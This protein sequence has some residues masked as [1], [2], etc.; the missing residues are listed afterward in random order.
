MLSHGR[1]RLPR[2]P[3]RQTGLSIVELLV[4]STIG[5]FLVG[6]AAKLFID[7]I[8]D[9]R[10]MIIETRVNQ[11]L[12]AAADLMARD[13]RR[14]GY[15]QAALAGAVYPAMLNPYRGTTPTSTATNSTTYAFSRDAT[16][17]NTLDGNES[18]GFRLQNNAIE[19]RVGS[20]TWQQVTDPG[21]VTVTQFTVTP[22]QRVV[23]V[24][25]YCTP[26]C[27]AGSAGCPSLVVRRFDIV[28]QGQAPS[29]ANVRREIRESVRLRNDEL[30]LASCP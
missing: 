2:H 7:S 25:Q 17:N 29:D 24:G 18:F 11:D 21:A 23:P 8:G 27:A 22:V 20:G 3:Q 16:E 12:R 5:L 10:R 14:A 15:W 4:G 30:P 28:L 6:G 19:T 13:L 1:A 9:T 26:A